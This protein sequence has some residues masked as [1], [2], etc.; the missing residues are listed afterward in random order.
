[1]RAAV[2]LFAATSLLFG[3]LR[4]EP[5]LA[6]ETGQ[7]AQPSALE[8]H[9][10]VT[11]TRIPEKTGTTPASV[12][13]ITREELIRRGAYDLRSALALAA[14]VD[15]AAGGDGGPASF[16]PEIWGLKESD[17]FLLAVDGVPSGGAFNPAL[18]TLDLEDVD[19]IEVLRG[20][21][22]VMYGATSFVGVINV[23]HRA[24]GEGGQ[25][26]RAAAAS[27][28]SGSV[29]W[30]RALP[31]WIGL[32]SSLDVDATRQG[33]S[34]DRTGFDRGHL[35]W[36]NTRSIGK[37]RLRFNLDGTWL[38]QD[39]ASPHPR[40][41]TTLSPLVPLDANHNPGGAHLNERRHTL[42]VFYERPFRSGT[43]SHSVSA[44][45]SEQNVLRGFLSD[46][47][48]ASPDAN[49]FR[50]ILPTFDLYFDSHVA[51]APTAGV[52]VLAGVDHL[53]GRGRARGGDF[54]YFVNLDGSTAPSGDSLDDQSSVRITDRREFS[55]VYGQL[56]W[57]PVERWHVEVGGRLN[58]TAETR[59]TN[60]LEFSVGV[61]E[62]GE[63][64]HATIRGSGFAGLTVTVWQR[65]SDSLR[66]FANA[67]NTFKPA[68]I[69]FGLDAKPDILA[70]ETAQS[71][72][73]GAKTRLLDDHLALELSAF[74]MDFENLVLSE[75]IGGVPALANGGTQRF[76]GAEIEAVARLR[77]DLTWRGV[78]SLHDAR[79]RD[80]VTEFEGVPTQLAGKRL[81]MSARHMAATEMLFGRSSGWQGS[82][83]AEWVGSRFLNK[84]NTALAP[85]YLTWSA[86]VAYRLKNVEIR[87]DGWNINDRRPPVAE[88]ELG[89][90]QYYRLPARRFEVSTRWLIGGGRD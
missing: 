53:H 84:R 82:L 55:G 83:R 9:V 64:R 75:S 22:P 23:I 10:Q 28:E 15:V 69:D 12:T 57:T 2:R 73:G 51:L 39:P 25:V 30:H 50:E 78:Y 65:G 62:T 48:G 37:G 52:E 20:A 68:A 66:L 79:F 67:R 40:E 16:V 43:W 71:Y 24:P 89:D 27:Y 77:P 90:A 29:A 35:R 88:S 49:G 76:R 13:V 70:P 80:F 31:Q 86:G 72:E 36:Q 41:D 56:T 44:S 1:M 59:S 8:E 33:F 54:D 60:S 21:A 61:P 74:Q 26:L 7:S 87:L 81:E 58:R 85:D 14:G 18:A 63:D 3:P 45:R 42:D 19:R 5:L 6:E 38:R 34:D 17:A 46:L 32:A 4:P 47:S 11:A